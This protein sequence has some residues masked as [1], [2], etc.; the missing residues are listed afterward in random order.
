MSYDEHLISMAGGDGERDHIGSVTEYVRQRRLLSKDLGLVVHGVFS[1]P[2]AEMADLTV[3]HLEA[4]LTMVREQRAVIERVRELAENA[5][6]MQNM[7]GWS[8]GIVIASDLIAALATR[9]QS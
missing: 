3:D 5:P 9:E 6:K 7:G 4:L 1:D 2:E 8:P